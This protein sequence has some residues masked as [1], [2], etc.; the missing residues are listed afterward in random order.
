[1]KLDVR[2]V[3]HQRIERRCVWRVKKM[4]AVVFDLR[5]V[6]CHEPDEHRVKRIEQRGTATKIRLK[7]DDGPRFAS[8]SICVVPIEKPLRLGQ[9]ETV[10]ALLDVADAEEV[11]AG[12]SFATD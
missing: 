8:R 2:P 1:M 10:D 11:P 12:V 5:R 9:A 3:E 4:R 6:L 7:V